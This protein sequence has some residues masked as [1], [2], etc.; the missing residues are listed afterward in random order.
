[1][2]RSVNNQI[3]TQ[4]MYAGLLSNIICMPLLTWRIIFAPLHPEVKK[5]T[6]TA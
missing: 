5:H 1:M 2:K 6:V 4:I 3:I